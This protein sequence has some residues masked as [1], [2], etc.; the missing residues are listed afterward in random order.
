MSAPHQVALFVG[1][2]ASATRR[3]PCLST[4][5]TRGRGRMCSNG[6]S[7][8][9]PI[10]DG[11]H[12][13]RRADAACRAT[14]RSSHAVVCGCLGLHGPSSSRRNPAS[15]ACVEQVMPDRALRSTAIDGCDQ[16]E[17]SAS[18]VPWYSVDGVERRTCSVGWRGRAP[19]MHL[20]SAGGCVL[21]QWRLAAGTQTGATCAEHQGGPLPLPRMLVPVEVSRCRA[22]VR[23]F[24]ACVPTVCGVASPAPRAAPRVC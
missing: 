7:A 10:G 9:A 6:R 20:A 3:C 23:R 19:R 11:C 17:T 16:H 8:N 15:Q 2:G 1:P 14:C 4:S 5:V 22:A 24:V 18:N 21:W 13:R 12:P